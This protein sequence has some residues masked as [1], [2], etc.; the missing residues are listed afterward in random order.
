MKLWE[1]G[2]E[3]NQDIETYTVGDDYLLDRRLVKYDCAAS[4][5]HARMLHKIGVL[6]ARE[7]ADLSMG[8]HAVMAMQAEGDFEISRQ[9]EDC[10]TAIENY[11]V[12]RF[13]DVGKKIH[14]A[15]S[16]N[17]QVL[18]A[19]RLY[20]K[21]KLAELE[22]CLRG[23]IRAV[24]AQTA[25]HGRLAIPGFTHTR[26]AMPTTVGVWLG[27]YA[28][29]GRDSIGLTKTAL[30]LIDRSPLGSAAGFGV[31]VLKIDKKYTAGLLGFSGVLE[32]PVHAQHSRGKF[33]AFIL[34]LCTQIMLDINALASDL[35][36]FSQPELGVVALPE[37]FCSGSSI[38]PQK[39][40]PDVLEILRGSYHIVLGEEFKA[41]SLEGNL[42]SGYS[43]DT[44][45]GKAPLF[46]G[47]DTTL[48][49]LRTMTKVISHLCF[50]KEKR[51]L[52]PELFATEQAYRLVAKGVPFR[53]AY[54]QVAES[55][56]S[57]TP[58]GYKCPAPSR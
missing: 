48:T 46:N 52:P 2:Y 15:R 37:A 6:T 53:D 7:L 29:A 57:A 1:K 49:S 23:L 22:K 33:E 19:L 50:S 8:L 9:D 13:G 56:K 38:M 14:T 18:A 51:A 26:R 36:F 40:N 24:A 10:H 17:D 58:A 47:L 39:R 4:L 44:Q 27:A 25:K 3:F 20:E 12:A 55:F 31:P 34:H 16:R 30:K 41:L 42:L 54:R 35:I 45:L 28:C 21:D 32:N 43:R 11:L 5:A